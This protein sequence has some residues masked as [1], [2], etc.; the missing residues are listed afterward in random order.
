MKLS[1]VT[2]NYNHKYFPKLSVEALEKS[3]TNFPFEI[4][5]VD[6]ASTDPISVGFLEK[7]SEGGRIKLVKSPR[8]VGFAGGNNL[9]AANAMG[10]YIFIL[11]PDTTVKPDTLQIMVD[12]LEAHPDIGMLGPQL[13][14]PDGAIQESCR[15]DMGFFDLVIKRTFLR[16]LPIFKK[17][18]ARYLMQDVSHDQTRD[19]ELIT[20]AAMMMPRRIFDEVG[21]FD[22]RYFLFME[23]FDLCKKVRAAGY[24]IVYLPRAP[25]DHYHKRLSDGNIFTLLTKRVFWLHVNSARKYFWKWRGTHGGV[26][27]TGHNDITA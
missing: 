15:R 5:Y 25:I 27:H 20:G 4:V 17:R 9:G 6:N 7:A 23:D 16:Y 21:G 10:E 11:N 24:R 3:V 8:N 13:V 1:I 26:H 12:Y 14:Y 19:V 22:D 2:V 18:L